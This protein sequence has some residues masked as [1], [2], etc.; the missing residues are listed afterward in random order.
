MK[1]TYGFTLK[2]NVCIKA[3]ALLNDCS[4]CQV[5]FTLNK[6]ENYLCRNLFSQSYTLG[7]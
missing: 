5:S 7:L 3:I 6:S 2:N 4:N 1:V